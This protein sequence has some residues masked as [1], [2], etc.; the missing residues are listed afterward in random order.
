MPPIRTFRRAADQRRDAGTEQ[1]AGRSAPQPILQ[2]Y[3]PAQQQI[4]FN[5][6]NLN[7]LVCSWEKERWFREQYFDWA[8]YWKAECDGLATKYHALE[9]E[10]VSFDCIICGACSYVA[11]WNLSSNTEPC[12]SD[13]KKVSTK[14]RNSKLQKRP[15][16][17]YHNNACVEWKR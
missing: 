9:R 8:N 11:R 16:T 6:L 4:D 13:Y 3:L 12:M 15:A 17:N 5:E 7:K 10:K 2:Q 14:S 1:P